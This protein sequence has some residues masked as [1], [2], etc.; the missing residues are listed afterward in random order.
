[1]KRERVLTPNRISFNKKFSIAI[2]LTMQLF[3]YLLV[4]GA[5]FQQL[6]GSLESLSGTGKQKVKML[7]QQGYTA[8][9]LPGAERT[10]L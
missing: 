4:M 3:N 5:L 6:S 9:I 2:I 8:V 7:T 10:P 1:M